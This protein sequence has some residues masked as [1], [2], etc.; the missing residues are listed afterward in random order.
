MENI[1]IIDIG[2]NSMRLLVVQIGED[3]SFKIIDEFSQS[4]RLGKDMGPDNRLDP[5]RMSKAFE[6]LQFFVNLCNSA[7]V[8]EK[9][10]VATEAVRKAS[11]QEEFLL[12]VKK[13]FNLDIR[14]L[15]GDQEAY[16]DYFGIINSM[17]ISQALAIDMGGSS[18]EIILVKDRAAANSI[19]LPYGA[20][21]LTDKYNSLKPSEGQNQDFFKLF[22]EDL[23]KNVPWLSEASGYPL[24]G[25][26][27]TVRNIGKIDRK[28][29]GVALD[30][31]HNYHMTNTDISQIYY[32]IKG[33]RPDEIK[34]IKGL[35]KE[36]AD[37]FAGPLGAINTLVEYCCIRD[38][39][40]SGSGLREG[41][42]YEYIQKGRQ[43][44]DN[45]LDFSL[46]NILGIY[47]L[48]KK[49]AIQVW[50]LFDSLFMQLKSLHKIAT[51]PYKIMKTAALLH[52]SGVNIDYN[53]HH[54]HSFYM[55]L[56]SGINGLSHKQLLSA[57]FIAGFHRKEE[58]KINAN[59][60]RAI[61]NDED[62]G[63]I[64]KLG[65]LLKLSESLDR[66]MNGNIYALQCV[67]GDNEVIIKLS[68]AENPELEINDAMESSELFKKIFNK[69]LILC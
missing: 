18:M 12:S 28:K 16:Y 29:K 17:D 42:I 35:S 67:I 2:S 69:K 30:I 46:N 54:K 40:I 36:R 59:T 56:N 61:L 45:V 47:N 11:N 57:A 15:S 62:I 7:G 53:D 27:G 20:I 41:L 26:G 13:E 68:S 44:V 49:H 10:A 34:K 31:I 58:F 32:D 60:Y 6:T 22:I 24:V 64:Q 39:Y 8:T 19:S 38:I 37:I 1:G 52:D 5:G 25:I 14:V 66:M 21:S 9:I 43:P 48:N 65:I 55:I 63:M 4:V 50:N 3:R 23:F 51:Y 33:K